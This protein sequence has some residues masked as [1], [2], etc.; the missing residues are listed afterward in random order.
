MGFLAKHYIGSIEKSL[1][2]Y[3]S[4]ILEN[5]DIFEMKKKLPNITFA[6]G[7]PCE[8]LYSGTKQ[9]CI[10]YAKKLIDEVGYDGS[11]IFSQNRMVSFKNDCNA[12]NL[13]AVNNFVREYGVM[14]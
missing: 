10:D 1:R 5:D 8:L 13:L 11:Y 6:G 9:Q 2:R 3:Y 4:A 7:M 14:K 12:E